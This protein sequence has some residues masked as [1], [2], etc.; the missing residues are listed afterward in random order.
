MRRASWVKR[1]IAIRRLTVR[2][3]SRCI[4]ALYAQG[5]GVPQ[6]Y[7]EAAKWFRTAADQGYAAGQF[8]LAKAYANGQGVPQDYV[9]AYSWFKLAAASAVDDEHHSLANKESAS[10]AAKIT[11]EPRHR[12]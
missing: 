7:T 5:H 12:G 3:A 11:P 4:G 8:N 6:D 2:S 10:L 9:Q 1:C